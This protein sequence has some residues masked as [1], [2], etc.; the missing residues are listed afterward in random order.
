VAIRWAIVGVGVIV[1]GW[2]SAGQAGPVVVLEGWAG[3]GAVIRGRGMSGDLV[4][5]DAEAQWDR[6]APRDAGRYS[7]RVTLPGGLVDTRP[8]PVQNPPGGR[9]FAV[10]I[11]AAPLRNLAPASVALTVEVVDAASGVAM[12]NPLT[13]TIAEM[14]RPKGDPSTLDPG[15]FGWGKPLGDGDRA[16]PNPGPD[17]LRFVRIEGPAVAP[18]TF[19]ATTEAT[20]QQVADRL[21]GYDPRKGRSDEFA[22]EGPDQPALNLTAARAAEYLGG[23]SKSDPSGVAYRLPTRDEWLAGA[24]AGKASAFWWGDEPTH[25]EGANLLGP[26]PALA[27]DATAP[28][29]P[30]EE[31]P[32]FA[33]N[34]LGLS[35]TFGNV[36]EWATDPTGG[37]ARMGGNFRTE[38]AAPLPSVAVAKDDDLGPDPFVGVRPAFTLSAQAG[39]DLAA[40]R[41]ATDPRLAGVKLAYDPDRATLALSGPVADPAARKAADRLLEGLPFVASVENRLETPSVAPG[42][43]ASLGGPVA[44][45]RK[46]AS[47]G[48]TFLEV[49]IAARWFDPLPVEG[50]DWWVNVYLPGGGHVAHRLAEGGPGRADKVLVAIDRDRMA[51][52]GL[53]DDA[54]FTVALSLGGPAPTPGDARVISNVT[55]VRPVVAPPPPPPPS[56]RARRS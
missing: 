19:L 13:A 3:E 23:L 54:P 18:G 47:L 35:H 34:P 25:P 21:P 16:L 36:A 56:I 43:L 31:S 41:L 6:S 20:N 5:L 50:S 46:V 7:I 32:T 17:G 38:P 33:S 10:Y 29:R 44:P 26:E 14:P 40:R 45:A 15:P 4:R 28:S 8:Y 55:A 11:P 2:P 52:A 12:S 30:R 22:L 51:A 27:G 39:A 49:P 48:K 42:Q 1:A 37:F 53:A 9:R 24:K